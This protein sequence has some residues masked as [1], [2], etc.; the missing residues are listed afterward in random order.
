M[1]V[2]G[3]EENEV[4][5]VAVWYQGEVAH[6]SMTPISTVQDLNAA[7]SDY[8][9]LTK[10]TLSAENCGVFA[11]DIRL[12]EIQADQI[13]VITDASDDEFD[14]LPAYPP[15]S[16]VMATT[17]A[18]D[19]HRHRTHKHRHH[20]HRHHR[21]RDAQQ[22]IAVSADDDYPPTPSHRTP[23][24]PK[25]PA[26][27]SGE[28][29]AADGVVMLSKRPSRPTTPHGARPEDPMGGTRATTPNRPRTPQRTTQIH[30]TAHGLPATSQRANLPRRGASPRASSPSPAPRAPSPS[31]APRSR[32]ASSPAL[33]RT[34]TADPA[35]LTRTHTAD[36]M[37]RSRH[38]LPGTTPIP[39]SPEPEPEEPQLDEA[40][41][42]DGGEPEPQYDDP[43]DE[44]AVVWQEE[45]GPPPMGAPPPHTVHHPQPGA[46]LRGH[47]HQHQHPHPHPHRWPSP[48]CQ[49]MCLHQ[50][51]FGPNRSQFPC[52]RMS[53]HPHQSRLPCLRMCRY[54]CRSPRL[55]LCLCLRGPRPCPRRHTSWA[56]SRPRR[57]CLWRDTCPRS[58]RGACL[59]GD[60][61][62]RPQ[63]R[64][65]CPRGCAG[66]RPA[67]GPTGPHPP[68]HRAGCPRGCA[69]P[70]RPGCSTGDVDALPHRGEP[71]T[72]SARRATRLGT[73]NLRQARGTGRRPRLCM[74]A[75]PAGCARARSTAWECEP[76]GWPEPQ[77]SSSRVEV[78]GRPQRLRRDI[79]VPERR[80]TGHP[81][82]GHPGPL[83]CKPRTSITNPHALAR[84]QARDAAQADAGK[85]HAPCHA[86]APT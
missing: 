9:G 26:T 49:R 38:S 10:C 62:S 55:C 7:V 23:R 22:T 37:A 80:L 41:G 44:Q 58:T 65:V 53:P 17:P 29:F 4:I 82:R 59:R 21:S 36:P 24:P 2:S 61:P 68:Q 51:R 83:S 40:A 50:S 28:H 72:R 34:H 52:Q 76:R 1:S 79:D 70:L 60:S 30:S 74:D 15:G 6:F 20:K 16:D 12:Q 64:G 67:C 69:G 54:L 32:R 47:P 33:T 81:Q 13:K 66:P 86:A 42:Y 39:A 85:H 11:N 78:G 14:H 27:P 84:A 45:P 77:R 35:A 18:T 48:R 73:L 25:P 57:V 31:P 46:G 5:T 43:Y 8:W 71:R 63:H 3:G 19:T 56:C 75:P